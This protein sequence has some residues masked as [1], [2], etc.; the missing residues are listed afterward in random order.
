MS[1]VFHGLTKRDIS[2]FERYYLMDLVS[3][4][5]D[6]VPCHPD[7]AI[8]TMSEEILLSYKGREVMILEECSGVESILAIRAIDGV[9]LDEPSY[10][11]DTEYRDRRF[12]CKIWNIMVA[13]YS[14]KQQ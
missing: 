5:Q 1:T 13:L 8:P 7:D 12:I 6:K 3:W 2:G 9:V 14:R 11:A 4:Y 10:R